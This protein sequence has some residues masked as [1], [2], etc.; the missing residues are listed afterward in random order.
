MENFVFYAVSQSHYTDMKGYYFGYLQSVS[1]AAVCYAGRAIRYF[2]QI[3]SPREFTIGFAS[4]LIG[5]LM[6]HSYYYS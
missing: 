6:K 1:A 5:C 2:N 3:A 4:S